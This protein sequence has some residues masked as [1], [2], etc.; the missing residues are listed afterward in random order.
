MMKGNKKV[1]VLAVL[2]LLLSVAGTFAIYRNS[3]AGTGT[4]DAAAWS[5][6][7]NGDDIETAAFTFDYSDITWTTLTGYNNTIAP[8]STGVI[9]I[10]VDAT[11]S[12]VDVIVTAALGQATL[13]SGMTVSLATGSDSQT[14]AY[15]SSS[16]TTNVS[17]NIVWSGS[18][19]DQSSKDE[20][21]LGV[22]NTTISIP[23]TLT[24]KQSVTGHT[25]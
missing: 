22:E 10:P 9:N 16:M 2:V 8:G 18:D 4:V 15:S 20:S 7:V 24:A 13:P 1:L 23:V 11:G 12:E 21:D 3:A 6:Q 5:V 19:S 25:S 14:I 17:L